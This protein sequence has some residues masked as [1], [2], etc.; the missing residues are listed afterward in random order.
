MPGKYLQPET[1][2]ELKKVWI[3]A[4]SVGFFET[5]PDDNERALAAS[6]GGEFEGK[7][8]L[9]FFGLKESGW[10]FSNQAQADKF[11][12]ARARKIEKGEISSNALDK[13]L[14]GGS[15]AVKDSLKG[16]TEGLGINLT[17]I[18]LIAGALGAFFI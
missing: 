14:K 7:G 6:F 1:P 9:S 2:P 11:I 15:E 5:E 4:K 12:A 8:L 10:W 16:I 17:Q 13:A 3:S 18:L